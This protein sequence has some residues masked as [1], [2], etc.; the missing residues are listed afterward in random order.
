MYS[1]PGTKFKLRLNWKL[2]VNI[3]YMIKNFLKWC[4]LREDATTVPGL[5]GNRQKKKG[6]IKWALQ[7]CILHPEP[8]NFLLWFLFFSP[9]KLQQQQWKVSSAGR[10]ENN[11]KCRQQKPQWTENA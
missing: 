1:S 9:Q 11:N 5:S 2:L 10:N 3:F 8:A 6:N 7:L 4:L